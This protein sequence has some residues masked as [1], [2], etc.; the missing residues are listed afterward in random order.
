MANL[1]TNDGKTFLY[2]VCEENE[3]ETLRFL[4][5][6]DFC[7]LLD[8]NAFANNGLTPLHIAVTNGHIEVV[9]LLLENSTKL[10]ITM[11]DSVLTSIHK[12]A[13]NGHVEV[14]KLLLEKSLELINQ[15]SVL[16]FFC[17]PGGLPTDPN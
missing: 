10:K 5:D 7:S 3:V 1:Q 13:T 16:R 17:L 12:A 4:F 6:S 15:K 9:K 2:L 14:V 11:N 8:F